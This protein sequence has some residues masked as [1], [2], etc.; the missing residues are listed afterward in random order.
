LSPHNEC[1]RNLLAIFCK[2]RL[3]VNRLYRYHIGFHPILLPSTESQHKPVST[4]EGD[5]TAA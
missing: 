5:I 2:H 4:L 1:A 3:I